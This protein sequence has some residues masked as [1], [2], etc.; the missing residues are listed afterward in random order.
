M[1]NVYF[2]RHGKTK[3]NKKKIHQ[4]PDT[5][6]CDLGEEQAHHI[7]EQLNEVPIDIIIASPLARTRKTAEIISNVIGV[8]VEYSDLLV[9]LR[10]P[11]ELWGVSWKTLKSMWIMGNLYL[12]V[13]DPKWHYSDEE[14]LYEFHTRAN[15][16]LE[17][18]AQRPEKNILVVTHR[19]LMAN[20]L[21][22]IK[23]DGLDTIKQYRRALWKNLTI[24]NCCFYK[25]QWTPEGEWGETLSGTWFVESKPI[26]PN[27]KER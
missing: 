1:K 27:M 19:G 26:C 22:K 25:T 6:L 8:T 20:M 17:Y 12:R 24:G 21:S 18:I 11:T 2:L 7:A 3:L 23:H 14:N 5:P 13:R 4:F 16:A 10:R 9:E 15:Q